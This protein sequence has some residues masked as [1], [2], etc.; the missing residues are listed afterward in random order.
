[1][2]KELTEVDQEARFI[3]RICCRFASGLIDY[4]GDGDDFTLKSA[5]KQSLLD[6]VQTNG[7]PVAY[8][9]LLLKYVKEG[10]HVNEGFGE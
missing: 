7:I 4:L 5:I 9:N 3:A 8:E 2:N 1:M 10:L 6:Y